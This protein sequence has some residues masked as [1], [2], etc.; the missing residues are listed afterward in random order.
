M[1]S[2]ESAGYVLGVDAG[3]TKTIALVARTD[4]PIV[5]AGRGGCGDVYGEN[6]VDGALAA[7]AEAVES[8]LGAA[9]VRRHDLT[10]GLFSMAGADWP[11]DVDFLLAAMGERGFGRTVRVVNDAIGALRAGSADGTGVVVA[12]G[13]GIA[14]GARAADGR[15]WHSGF[16]AEPHGSQE[17]ARRTFR[18]VLH[19]ELGI[20]PPTS[21]TGQ[22]IGFLGR[23]G[24]ED[25]LHLL[26][27]RDA[28]VRPRDL[29]G[30]SRVLLDEAAGGDAV[31]RRIVAE[32][33]T[34]LG[35]Y[36]V[37]AARRVGIDG[38]AFTLVLTGGVFRHPACQ[39]AEAVVARVRTASPAARSVR[40]GFE[41]AVGALFLA[42]EIAGIPIDEA[43]LTRLVPTIPAASF[44]AT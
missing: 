32:Q 22:V 27:A 23:R 18:A 13:T 16:W 12:C 21:L 41:P 20:E 25:A 28:V 2:G 37:A 15:A 8:A 1:A 9:A 7:V 42:L 4:G 5:G 17:L 30:L 38:T 14:I 29:A 26:T 36:A 11:E 34:V 44:F 24:V 40:G 33:G 39:L 6:G 10:V 3:N 31:A 43:L 19:A 35:D